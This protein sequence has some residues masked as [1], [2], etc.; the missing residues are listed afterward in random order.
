MDGNTRIGMSHERVK[1]YCK[2]CKKHF[3]YSYNGCKPMSENSSCP[4]CSKNDQVE[5]E[6]WIDNHIDLLQHLVYIH[7]EEKQKIIREEIY[8]LYKIKGEFRER[9]RY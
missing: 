2:R 7:K 8:E 3:T 4:E 6:K 9:K 5:T 1:A